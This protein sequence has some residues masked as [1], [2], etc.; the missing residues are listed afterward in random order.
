MSYK[1]FYRPDYTHNLKM[2]EMM[3][4][5]DPSED[6]KSNDLQP[7]AHRFIKPDIYSCARYVRNF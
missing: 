7:A 1:T 6:S 2:T 5:T 3:N 4:Q